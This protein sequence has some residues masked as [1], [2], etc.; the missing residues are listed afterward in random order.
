MRLSLWLTPLAVNISV[1]LMF[2]MSLSERRDS[3]IRYY[4]TLSG[5]SLCFLSGV[6]GRM[7]KVNDS[8]KAECSSRLHHDIY[9]AKSTEYALVVLSDKFL[10]VLRYAMNSSTYEFAGELSEV[11]DKSITFQYT[12]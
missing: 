4:P 12:S 3:S 8:T 2:V 10:T 6:Q 11:C 7:L 1:N 9:E 5:T